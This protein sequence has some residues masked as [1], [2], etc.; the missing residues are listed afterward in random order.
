MTSA[1]GTISIYKPTYYTRNGSIVR[2]RYINTADSNG[3][4]PVTD[5]C[6]RSATIMSDD[7]VKLS[8]KLLEQYVFEAF[9]YIWYDNQLFFLKEQYRPT[10]KG[11]YYQYEM[12]FVSIA[13]M[14]DKH[15][16]LRYLTVVETDPEPEINMNGTLDDMV[17][18]VLGSIQG[19]ASR[20][21][22]N[23]PDLYYTY[24]LGNLELAE[25]TL[26]GTTLQTFS[27]SG[28]NISDVL[29][30][31]AEVY[32]IEWWITQESM[33][34]IKLHL[35]KC[36]CNDT[37]IVSDTFKETGDSLQP[38]ASRGLLSCEYSQEWSNITQKIIPFGSERNITRKQ[39]LEDINGNSMYV[40]YGKQLRLA[41]NTDYTV[42]DHD[43]NTL[44][45]R[46]DSVGAL[47]NAGVKSGIETIKQ[48][49]DIYPR[50]HFRVIGVSQQGT[51]NPIYTI[52]AAAIKADGES[53]MSYDDMVA[54]G[55]LPLQIEPNETL[56]VIF[57]S[58]YLNGR[59]F[60]VKHSIKEA[61]ING[62]MVMQWTL[63]I[64]PEE[65]GDDGVSLPFGN[66]I[67]RAKTDAYEGDMFA[68]F[69][70]IMPQAYITRAQ[71][72]LAQAAYNELLAIEDTRPEIKCKSEPQFFANQTLC[73]GQRVAVHSELFGEIQLD[74]NGDIKNDSPSLFASRV[75]S[76]SHSLT[77]P[78]SVEFKLASSRVEGRLTEIEA[79]I[80]DQTNDIRGLEQ[81]SLNLSRR[82]WHDAEE[83]RNMLDSLAAEL[84]LVGVEKN[85]FAFTSAIYCVNGNVI[86]QQIDG[87]TKQV[88][89]FKHLHISA[90]YIQHTQ[91]PYIKYANGG[92][93]DINEIDIT[94]DEDG[95]S[96]L[97][98]ADD[99]TPSEKAY[100]L[101]AVCTSTSTTAQIVLSA[102]THDSDTD[103]LLM[104]ILSSEFLDTLKP[105]N[106]TS[107]RVFNRS[108]G[109][110]QVAG[111]TITTEQIQD[112]TR[113][114]IIDF[115][116][117]PPRI[118]AR[119][120]A[121]II[122]N[123]EFSL[124]ENNIQQVLQRIGTIGGE[125]LFDFGNPY[126]LAGGTS[127]YTFVVLLSNL[128]NGE[129]YTFSC[130][131]SERVAGTATKYSVVLYDFAADKS[132]QSQAL[133]IGNTARS[134]TFDIPD[135]GNN[136]SLLLYAGVSGSTAGNTVRWT[137]IMIQ[138][139]NTETAYQQPAWKQLYYEYETSME[140]VAT[141]Y[142]QSKVLLTNLPA[143][144]YK[145]MMTEEQ[146]GD[147]ATNA[148][149]SNSCLVWYDA[150]LGNPPDSD[151]MP[152]Y[153][154]RILAVTDWGEEV[155]LAQTAKVAVYT[156]TKEWALKAIKGELGTIEFSAAGTW[157]VRFAHISTYITDANLAETRALDYLKAALQGST[158][159][160][161]G[162]LMTNVLMLKNEKNKVTAGMSGLTGTETDPE[163][164]LLW[165]G[166]TYKEAL[167]AIQGLAYL[168]VL[169]TKAGAGSNIGC[170]KV[171]SD[172][173]TIMVTGAD[174]TMNV[175]ITSET[176]DYIS[177]NIYN[178]Y[179]YSYQS[180]GFIDIPIHNPQT[181]ELLSLP[182]LPDQNLTLNI[183]NICLYT[184]N[185]D[186]L[187][188]YSSFEFSVQLIDGSTTTNVPLVAKCAIL[189]VN[190]F[191]ESTL[192]ER[193]VATLR[194]DVEFDTI[195]VSVPSTKTE[196]YIGVNH[197]QCT[198]LDGKTL[199]SGVTYF[200][201]YEANMGTITRAYDA[202][203]L[204]NENGVTGLS[205]ADYPITNTN[206]G[207]IKL[208]AS[209][210]RA[211]AAGSCSFGK[212]SLFDTNGL[213]II[214]SDGI[215]L[216]KG[217]SRFMVNISDQL[218]IVLDGLPTENNTEKENH[219]YYKQDNTGART[220]MLS[221]TEQNS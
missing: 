14:L 32:E 185:T 92:R 88:N 188:L 203:D 43:G 100:Y 213:C 86:S 134:C 184:Q 50:C 89:H 38:Y 166:G 193:W 18:I 187:G 2:Q 95:N 144:K 106:V 204:S 186:T 40:S 171:M 196:D 15:L 215:T 96:I 107:F 157:V 109:Y 192:K 149:M 5:S 85:Q 90:G 67:P 199:T 20:L 33:T 99:T 105:Y 220:L 28:Q 172:N 23:Q 130:E 78:D 158:E 61:E 170:L 111:G 216:Q 164:V 208:I 169:L 21:S 68:I 218:D 135:D 104:G 174:G 72:E 87:S 63:T 9:A 83:M 206:A 173:K 211:T 73:L 183:D 207:Y 198:P 160:A 210:I 56:S 17:Q 119:N 165:G 116:S 11:S 31:I 153:S 4:F 202:T 139:G 122:G 175:V 133:T 29:T 35:C 127:D 191:D 51:D 189:Y 93:W 58:G 98:N 150:S 52:V 45:I 113:S 124:S 136:Y 42:K 151:I 25:D 24:V 10:A 125:N 110:T 212:L 146:R 167:K 54:A 101:Y 178:G 138:K 103:Y 117:T 182:L 82:G 75:T 209:D 69:H 129:S 16:C 194:A 152:S 64:V 145:A 47:T 59:E 81:R 108:N 27:F 12:K 6:E 214:A 195:A 155:T 159:I 70:M 132:I 219:L 57:E 76:F 3:D 121:K 197:S 77:K 154:N 142:I 37:I 36:E 126:Q 147:G 141:A 200:V 120:G 53:L 49:D 102:T 128:Q 74:A 143:G 112:P 66:F 137:D 217:T 71:E 7:Y 79:V 55:L 60:E 221:N 19:A 156:G 118:I 161:G 91:E 140:Y 148:Y 13:N 62:S 1:L 131:K 114:L 84:L 34:S 176:S 180:Y 30:E 168:P 123:I 97:Y 48:F 65:G 162:L 41:P 39:A 94:A 44:T 163:K 201:K 179:F 205:V 26:Q 22:S 46:T 80:A 177:K 181:K 8:F 115:Q 190:Y